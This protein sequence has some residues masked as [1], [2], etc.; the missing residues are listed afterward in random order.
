MKHPQ[1]DD[2][3]IK[4]LRMTLAPFTK[5]EKPQLFPRLAASFIKRAALHT[6]TG[7][8]RAGFASN[9][10]TLAGPSVR[11][12]LPI[13]I[14]LFS[15]FRR[16][17]ARRTVPASLIPGVPLAQWKDIAHLHA[18][19][20]SPVPICLGRH[21][22]ATEIDGGDRRERLAASCLEPVQAN[23]REN[24]PAMRREDPRHSNVSQAQ[25]D[26]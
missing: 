8:F 12:L 15:R 26:A 7:R 1:V 20:A 24:L 4:A 19:P 17:A 2:Q 5:P 23:S 14:E 9:K 18:M 22:I 21:I 10:P 11:P 3:L 6:R 16:L 25:L 13:F